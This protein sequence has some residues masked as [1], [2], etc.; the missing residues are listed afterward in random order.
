MV[1]AAWE[2]VSEAHSSGQRK[3]AVGALGHHLNGPQ[4]QLFL[5]SSDGFVHNLK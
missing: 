3:N 1:H 5:C 2:E 4:G